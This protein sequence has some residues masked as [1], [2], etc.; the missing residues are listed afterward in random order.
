MTIKYT[1]FKQCLCFLV[2]AV[3][4]SSCE[5]TDDTFALDKGQN[6]PGAPVADFTACSTSSLGK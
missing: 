6:V 5:K 1:Y 4:F 2:L 3:S